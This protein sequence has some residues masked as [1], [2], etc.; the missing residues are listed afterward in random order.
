MNDSSIKTK[1]GFLHIAKGIV[2]KFVDIMTGDDS[3]ERGIILDSKV[4]YKNQEYNVKKQILAGGYTSNL[5][6]LTLKDNT[7]GGE[8]QLILKSLSKRFTKEHPELEDMLEWEYDLYN[9]YNLNNCPYIVEIEAYLNE[10]KM[11]ISKFVKGDTLLDFIE[12]NPGYFY[13]RS[14]TIKFCMQLIDA[15]D[16]LHDKGI[17]HLDICPDNILIKG[18]GSYNMLLLNTGLGAAY[19]NNIKIGKCT[20][21]FAPPEMRSSTTH[22][23]IQSDMWQFGKIIEIIIRERMNDP[24]RVSNHLKAICNKCFS[25][26]PENRFKSFTQIRE[27]V[28]EWEHLYDKF[29]KTPR[30][31]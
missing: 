17:C 20:N 19:Y 23:S 28:L 29:G 4:T 5:F 7:S 24:T 25:N 11:L 27:K 10:Q 2:N 1:S 14:T 18:D 15:L 30:P 8:E 16:M 26:K 13:K 3:Y 22:P 9:N 12:K 21:E 6:L 31:D